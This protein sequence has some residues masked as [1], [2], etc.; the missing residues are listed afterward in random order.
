[1]DSLTLVSTAAWWLVEY[2]DVLALALFTGGAWYLL[3]GRHA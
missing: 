1:M 3:R 2:P